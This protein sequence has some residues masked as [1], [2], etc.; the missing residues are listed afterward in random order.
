[1][2]LVAAPGAAGSTSASPSPSPSSSVTASTSP[3]PT[4]TA[5][6]TPPLPASSATVAWS[7]KWR[8]LDT[9][10]QKRLNVARWWF[11]CKPVSRISKAPA[12][13][14]SH[15][16]W[17]S[18]GAS[19]KQQAKRFVRQRA[20]LAYRTEHPRHILSAYTWR[21]LVRRF[22]P[23]SLV[24]RALRVIRAESG[25]RPTARNGSG[26]S[27]LFQLLPGPAGWWIPKVNVIYAY[28]GKYLPALRACGDG[29]RPWAASGEGR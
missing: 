18:Y 10:A 4:P 26:A 20:V 3:S 12:R 2:L 15:D 5:T 25:G 11:S 21:P 14:A 1:M 7:L 29:F 28:V 6:P 9:R 8:R 13:A 19:C 23:A 24:E 16:A 17:Q 27:G 22:W